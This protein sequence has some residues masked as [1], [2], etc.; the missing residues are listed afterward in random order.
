[1]ADADDMPGFLVF[2]L[3]ECQPIGT[4]RV[5][6]SW[7]EIAAPIARTA[8]VYTRPA[9]SVFLAVIA[10]TPSYRVDEHT[11]RILP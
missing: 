6:L 8:S 1:M 10:V 3:G 9:P 5:Y 4:L 2:E 11:H 7:A